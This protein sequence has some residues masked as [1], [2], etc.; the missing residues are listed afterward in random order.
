MRVTPG[1]KTH[2]MS[3]M[4]NV[5]ARI[6]KSDCHIKCSLFSQN[7]FDNNSLPNRPIQVP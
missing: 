6:L 7:E 1:S 5:L 3:L 4:L 2:T